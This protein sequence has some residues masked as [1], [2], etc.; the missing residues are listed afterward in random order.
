MEDTCEIGE[1]NQTVLNPLPTAAVC[2]KVAYR[3]GKSY[4]K[5]LMQNTHIDAYGLTEE[6]STSMPQ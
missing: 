3:S 5:Y 4:I 2:V 6:V 1:H